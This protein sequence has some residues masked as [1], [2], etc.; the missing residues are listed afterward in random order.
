M[1]LKALVPAAAKSPRLF[2]MAE[3]YTIGCI[4]MTVSARR[5]P[6]KQNP[7]RYT[8]APK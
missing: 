6:L 2:T 7:L 5:A 8:G 1:R 4:V 3:V